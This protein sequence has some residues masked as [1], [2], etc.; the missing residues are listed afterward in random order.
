MK[1]SV[2][3]QLRPSDD[4]V[5]AILAR[6]EHI[7]EVYFAW[8][9]FANGRSDSSSAAGFAPWEAQE[10]I[11]Q[12]LTRI[13]HA[14]I[15]TN[16]LLNA[17]CYGAE[18]QSR[19]LFNRIGETVDYVSSRLNTKSVTTTSPL[20]AKFVKNNF[21]NI[22]TRASVNMEIGTVQ[23]MDYLAQYFD[24]AA[25]VVNPYEED[26]ADVRTVSVEPDGSALGGNVYTD[27]IADILNEKNE[28]LLA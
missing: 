3:Y 14:E 1:F 28:S 18:S 9:G 20:I 17:M 13:A 10:R 24:A 6:R 2:G 12:D 16:L 26:P 21:P 22:A 7:A 23:G 8:P 27:S 25:P 15:P 19:Q 4:W 5:D 11:G